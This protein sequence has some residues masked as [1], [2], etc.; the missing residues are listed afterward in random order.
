MMLSLILGLAVLNCGRKCVE[1]NSKL[2][3]I[4]MIS[5]AFQKCGVICI[6]DVDLIRSNDAQFFVISQMY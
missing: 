5:A 1:E 2:V 3:V 4:G 6:F